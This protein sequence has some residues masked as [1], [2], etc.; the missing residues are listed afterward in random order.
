MPGRHNPTLRQ[1][2]LGAELRRMREQAGLGGS[3]LARTLG[4]SAAH[5]TQLETGKSSVSADRLRSFAA[6]CKCTNQPLIDAL[7]GVAAERTR[8][9]WDE[10]RG[11]LGAAFLDVAELEG[12]ADGI[13][14]YT[15][16]FVPGLLQTKAYATSVFNRAIPPLP[17]HEVDTRL[18]FRLQR[19]NVVRSGKTT[20]SAFIHEAALRMQFSGPTVLAEQLDSL[21]KD[22]E[23]QS[24]TVR[25][26]PFEIESLPGPSE[27]FTYARGPVP[28]LDTIQMDVSYGHLLLDAPAQLANYREILTRMASVALTE[29]DSREFILSIKKE[30]ESKNG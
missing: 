24:I 3:E 11:T 30:I 14:T 26:V 13:V 12:Y 1:R 25:V 18:A 22:S 10:Y 19:Q 6:A 16:T 27:N 21:I 5:V 20:Y 8:N 2:R 7:A 4:V 23:S 28:E 29:E 9:W 15:I 17:Q